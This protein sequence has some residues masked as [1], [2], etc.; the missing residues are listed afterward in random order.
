M[1]NIIVD[2]NIIISSLIKKI[3]EIKEYLLREDVSY[4]SREFILHD[5]T[6]HK[7]K[8]ENSKKRCHAREINLGGEI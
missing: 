6:K 8:I 5:L 2:A 3:S 4:F 1:N 7:S